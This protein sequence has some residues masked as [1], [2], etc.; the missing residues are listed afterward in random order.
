MLIENYGVILG[1]Q[2]IKDIIL[3]SLP[4]FTRYNLSILTEESKNLKVKK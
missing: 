3:V 1:I 2:G 4:M